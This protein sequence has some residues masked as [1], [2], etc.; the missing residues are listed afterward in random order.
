MEKY[1]NKFHK[2]YVGGEGEVGDKC[3][4]S[5]KVEVVSMSY[6][7]VLQEYRRYVGDMEAE[8]PQDIISQLE[9]SKKI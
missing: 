3:I 1:D 4:P 5:K 2:W 9:L 6:E 7:E 8:L